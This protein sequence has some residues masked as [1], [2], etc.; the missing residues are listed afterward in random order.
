M[1]ENL[2]SVGGRPNPPIDPDSQN[3]LVPNKRLGIPFSGS[4]VGPFVFQYV[5]SSISQSVKRTY[6]SR[7][8]YL[9]VGRTDQ[10]TGWTIDYSHAVWQ[11][12]ITARVE[13]SNF[14]SES[15]GCHY[16]ILA[17]LKSPPRAFLSKWVRVT[18]EPV[19]S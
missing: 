15:I 9:F 12:K 5:G 18:A 14:H 19:Y 8:R 13:E 3:C 7:K 4:A 2:P 10:P 17:F 11:P 16:G 1:I 6:G